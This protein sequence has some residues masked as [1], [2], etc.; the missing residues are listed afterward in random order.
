MTNPIKP[1]INELLA[2]N[3]YATNLQ[4]FAR[5]KVHA[6]TSGNHL[7]PARGRG[8]DF[9]EV[10]RY[11][12]G[13]DIRLIHWSLTARLGKPFTKI[14]R[15]ERERA[16]YVVVDQSAS[17][18]FGTRVCF[19]NVLAAKIAALFGWAALANH[20]QIGG[21]IFNDTAT[22]FIKPRRSRRSLLDLFS[23]LT[24]PERVCHHSG[25]LKNALQLLLRNLQSGSVVIIISDY[26]GWDSEIAAYLRLVGGNSEVINLLLYDP[27][28]VKLPDG[29]NY[30]FTK[31]GNLRLEISSNPKNNALY[32]APFNS[33]QAEL[34]TMGQKSNMQ[35]MAIS[36]QD[37]LVRTLNY[38]VSKYGY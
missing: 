29:G 20:E 4:F 36:P 5:H 31:D 12:A 1:E 3:Y 7:S 18:R 25:G 19:K 26:L 34:K 24:H 23:L 33:R 13:D 16:V 17:M 2:L 32:A 15:E 37:D 30:V 28:E 22:E 27:L 9:E 14:Y 35:F 6:P 21:I 38:G 11:Q 10:R 8:M